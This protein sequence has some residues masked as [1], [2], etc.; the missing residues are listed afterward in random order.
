VGRALTGAQK[1][2][3]GKPIVISKDPRAYPAP[4]AEPAKYGRAMWEYP[5][6]T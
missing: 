1:T 5:S 6:S 3:K 4:E 2:I